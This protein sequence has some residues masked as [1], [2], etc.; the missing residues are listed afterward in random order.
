MAR[1]PPHSC[2]PGLSRPP[3]L[4]S[5]PPGR[6]CGVFIRMVE[7]AVITDL[8]VWGLKQIFKERVQ[9]LDWPMA[10]R[11][12]SA[13][14]GGPR[15][16]GRAVPEDADTA[17][18][19]SSASGSPV[20][21]A[22][23]PGPPRPDSRSSAARSPAL[24][25]PIPDPL[26]PGPR[27]PIPGPRHPDS[28]PSDPRPSAPR[29]PALGAPIPGPL[30]PGPLRPFH[31]LGARTPPRAGTRL[32]TT[33]PDSSPHRTRCPGP[34]P[35]ALPP[36]PAP[37]LHASPRL[38]VPHPDP[39][40]WRRGPPH[41]PPSPTPRRPSARRP[42]CAVTLLRP[43]SVST[44]A[45]TSRGPRPRPGPGLAPPALSSENPRASDPGEVSG[46]ER[47][48]MG[49]PSCGGGGAGLRARGAGR[50]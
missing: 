50:P 30:I 25:T 16:C 47:G 7:K 40:S 37:A 45:A 11:L 8:M 14:R 29:S 1:S 24:G 32:S 20:L 31:T 49:Q 15:A 17:A 34:R 2:R 4:A 33:P 42:A 39:G 44:R 21:C 41:G 48:L 12:A 3:P 28:R 10:V 38:A 22:R 18:S 13:L 43:G 19:A 6:R 46:R 23:I 35:P 26:I 9:Y 27:H 36:P 5:P